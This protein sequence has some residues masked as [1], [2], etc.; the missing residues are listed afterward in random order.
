M[1]VRTPPFE[2]QEQTFRILSQR[3]GFS[4]QRSDTSAEGEINPFNESYLDELCKAI[5]LQA[6]IQIF[7][8]APENAHSG[9]FNVPCL[10]CLTSWPYNK[11]SETCQ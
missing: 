3:P 6:L 5:Q 2:M 1:I 8:F 11:S 9:E 7:A 4:H 10:R